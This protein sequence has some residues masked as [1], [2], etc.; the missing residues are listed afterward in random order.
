[1]LRPFVLSCALSLAAPAGWA[2]E[3]AGPRPEPRPE[4]IESASGDGE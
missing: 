2:Q 4:A 1:M 3:Q